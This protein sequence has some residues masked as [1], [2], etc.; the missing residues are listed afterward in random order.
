M[1]CQK[2][3]VFILSYTVFLYIFLNL[4][5]E[6]LEHVRT[7]CEQLQRDLDQSRKERVECRKG[8]EENGTDRASSTQTAK[9]NTEDGSANRVNQIIENRETNENPAGG[10]NA[11]TNAKCV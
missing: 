1:I 2:T 8:P 6:S 11:V 4:K 9:H 5:L 7:H 3:F 10:E